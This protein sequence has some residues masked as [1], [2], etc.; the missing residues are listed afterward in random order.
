MVCLCMHVNMF[1]SVYVC[2]FVNICVCVYVCLCK[3]V[4]VFWGV[5]DKWTDLILK[6]CIL[7]AEDLRF[8]FWS[9]VCPSPIIHLIILWELDAIFVVSAWALTKWVQPISWSLRTAMLTSLLAC[10][11]SDVYRA[12]G[13]TP[14]SQS[15]MYITMSRL[16]PLLSPIPY[17][18]T[19]LI[20]SGPLQEGP[21]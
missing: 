14:K 12:H 16:L 21:A 1:M 2:M 11:I 20:K 6:L 9:L 7:W 10:W 8:I 5:I 4:F 15:W 18:L 17:P 3:C 19:P 13:L